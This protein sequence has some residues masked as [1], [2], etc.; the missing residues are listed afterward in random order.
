MYYKRLY[1]RRVSFLSGRRCCSI[2]S[3][4]FAQEQLLNRIQCATWH[5]SS[6]ALP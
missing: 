5:Q 4:R 1:P 2:A 6:H 3:G